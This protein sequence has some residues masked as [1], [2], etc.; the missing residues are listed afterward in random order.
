MFKNKRKDSFISKIYTRLLPVQIILVAIQSINGIVDGVVGSRLLGSE[1]MAAVGLFSPLLSLL[2]AVAFII[3]LGSQVLGS[4][5]AGKG[6]AENTNRIFSITVCLITIVGVIVG[7]ILTV[8]SEPL[9]RLLKGDEL[10]AAYMRGVAFSFLFDVMGAIFA[11][12]L[13]LVGNVKKTYLGMTML[14][15]TNVLLNVIFIRQFDMG[16]F[17]LGFATTLSIVITCVVMG[18]GF[19]SKKSRVHLTLKELPWNKVLDIMKYGSSAATFNLVLALKGFALNY[20]VLY[21]GG[22]VALG[23]LSVYN[24]ILGVTGAISM[25]VG[26]TTLTI[27]SVFYGEGDSKAVKSVFDVSLR[28]GLI[29]SVIVV[30]GFMGLAGPMANMFY[31]NEPEAGKILRDII[32]LATMY[33]PLNIVLCV[34]TKMYHIKGKM[35]ITNV[36]S[37]LEN[38]LVIVV[39]LGMGAMFGLKGVWLSMPVS[40]LLLA[41]WI[42]LYSQLKNVLKEEKPENSFYVNI[43]KNDDIMA[44]VETTRQFILKHKPDTENVEELCTYVRRLL[45]EEKKQFGMFNYSAIYKDNEVTLRIRN[46]DKDSELIVNDAIYKTEKQ[47]YIGISEFKVESIE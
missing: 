19:F 21:I 15:V 30:V 3:I 18:H 44:I 26:T 29:L 9:A 41:A 24:S 45:E 40:G 25:G 5:Y 34:Y 31:G 36:L 22:D 27:G 42:V 7:I 16:V 35:I 20:I 17:G 13:Q 46:N 47:S 4:Q 6:E 33:I 23:A 39:A 32:I 10:L 28:M 11:D 38:G 8:F 43:Y 37:F 12:Y 1:A 2:Y 14:I